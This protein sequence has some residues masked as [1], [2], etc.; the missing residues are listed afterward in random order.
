MKKHTLHFVKA[1]YISFLL[2][3]LMMMPY[4]SI[5]Q[6][7]NPDIYDY[8]N[9]PNLS[10]RALPCQTDVNCPIDKG[11]SNPNMLEMRNSTVQLFVD[12][13]RNGSDFVGGTGTLIAVANQNFQS[14]LANATEYRFYI[15]TSAHLFYKISGRTTDYVNPATN[16]F[17]YFNNQYFYCEEPITRDPG[18]PYLGDGQYDFCLSNRL[19]NDVE[20]RMVHE[21]YEGN[22]ANHLIDNAPDY[23]LDYALIEVKL[24]SAN[25]IQRFLSYNP[26]FV[27][28]DFWAYL[29]FVLN[30]EDE[31]ELEKAVTPT[32][33]EEN[34]PAY[35]IS[36]P[37]RGVKKIHD[38]YTMRNWLLVADTQPF[39]Y[40]TWDGNF[41]GT[42]EPGSSGAGYFD[43]N[44]RIF[45]ILGGRHQAS[46]AQPTC[47][48]NDRL[49][50][51]S[52]GLNIHGI[53]QGINRIT[54]Q[55]SDYVFVN[56]LFKTN[57]MGLPIEGYCL[58]NDFLSQNTDWGGTCFDGIENNCEKLPDCNCEP[59]K[60]EYC[61]QV[62]ANGTY[63]NN[64]PPC[65]PTSSS[66]G[67]TPPSECAG[68]ISKVQPSG[69]CHSVAN[70]VK[71]RLRTNSNCDDVEVRW[72]KG[73][74]TIQTGDIEFINDLGINQN[75]D[76]HE[77]SFN[78]ATPPTYPYQAVYIA[79]LWSTSDNAYIAEERFP[80]TIYAPVT[81][82]AGP[83]Q[84]ICLGS[85]VSLGGSPTATGGT[86]NYS[87]HWTSD[88][89]T[90]NAWLTRGTRYSANPSF[91]PTA[92]GSYTYTLEARDGFAC[93]ASDVMTL[94][95][96]NPTSPAF[97]IMT[98]VPPNCT[99]NMM[100]ITISGTPFTHV[101]V[102]VNGSVVTTI[103]T[104]QPTSIAIP[105]N[106]NQIFLRGVGEGCTN[107]QV[108][109]LNL[110]PCGNSVSL[111]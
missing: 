49:L 39:Y 20:I 70:P 30:I 43:H 34:R 40:A 51:V 68:I 46:S 104:G 41:A 84:T 58:P 81:T 98:L 96:I 101:E 71:L 108:I 77:F 79:I 105:P 11:P 57:Q 44:G 82:N 50:F 106:T 69:Y 29:P 93:S 61:Q 73:T 64:C 19:S 86:G 3:A 42:P 31:K 65:R 7:L 80:I 5:A 110:N 83:D 27:G 78:F 62:C 111:S 89:T 94:T 25:A 28:W 10:E 33:Q 95:V 35:T 91:V 66:G 48:P 8:L 107:T 6:L 12:I 1:Q 2:V 109:N 90:A 54:S 37:K 74:E 76:E 9:S 45:A 53:F 72:F 17:I 23:R 47:D 85:S 60:Y 63:K 52:H 75:V 88:N 38:S 103:V 100:S 99:T 87:Y 56:E 21:G 92:A 13:N 18:D 16:L 55:R 22:M 36:H 97:S 32:S 14:P 24:K 15:L 102:L 4:F 67:G 59:D 26:C